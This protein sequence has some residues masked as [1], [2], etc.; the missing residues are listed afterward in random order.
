MLYEQL[1]YKLRDSLF[2]V[3]ASDLALDDL[4]YCRHDAMDVHSEGIKNVRSD[5][6]PKANPN[7]V[8]ELRITIPFQSRVKQDL[9]RWLIEEQIL[10]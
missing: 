3:L 8:L 4:T 6:K 7:V 10:T 5:L 9:R 1:R 2:K